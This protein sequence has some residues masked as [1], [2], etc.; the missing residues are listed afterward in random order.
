[1][2]RYRLLALLLLFLAGCT[3]QPPAQFAAEAP[4]GPNALLDGRLFG[5]G[6]ADAPADPGLLT[7]NDDMR[8]FLA[9]RVPERASDSRK[10]E[11]ILEGILAG[12]LELEY[13]NLLTL[14]ASEAFY[15][16]AGNCMSFTN[17]FL[18]LAR[19][20]GLRAS[21][22][23]VMVPPTWTEGDN[24]WFY[25]LHVNVLVDLPGAEQVVDFN[26]GDYL[27]AYPRRLIS[28]EAGESRYHNNLGVH[29]MTHDDPTRAFLHFR[30]A[31][32]LQPGA[33]HVW[34]NL[35]TLYRRQ[36]NLAEAEA[37]FRHA[38]DLDREPVAMSNLAR[39]YREQGMPTLAADYARQVERVR[40]KNPYYQYYRAKQSYDA[41]AYAAAQ[42]YLERALRTQAK[43]H[44]FHHLMAMILTQRHQ[45]E[46]ARKFLRQ[47]EA[48]AGDSDK[49][50]YGD[51]LELL[52]GG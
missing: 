52:A 49:R 4:P 46:L 20:V 23:E 17:L 21:Y 36:G 34:T 44:R 16:R 32:V 26:I 15:R 40:S 27:R 8:A 47:A 37:A 33:G 35:G 51:K 18:A 50:R 30:E 13:D 14:P 9:E 10:V 25:N 7:V 24:A 5:V 41:G 38:I 28:D 11:L 3:S 39:L 29:Y 1:M 6:P 45:P 43:D 31:L 48:L 22:Q 12:G 19:E 42:R 2:P